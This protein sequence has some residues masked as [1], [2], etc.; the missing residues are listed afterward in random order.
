MRSVANNLV[1]SLE[2]K[3]IR[4]ATTLCH[5]GRTRNGYVAARFILLSSTAKSSATSGYV[6]VPEPFGQSEARAVR[7]AERSK[8]KPSFFPAVDLIDAIWKHM[9]TWTLSITFMY[10]V[11]C[12]SF[13]FWCIFSN[14]LLWKTCSIF[15]LSFSLLS[16][17]GNNHF[18][19]HFW[20]IRPVLFL[21]K[22]GKGTVYE[23]RNGRIGV[24]ISRQSRHFS[25]CK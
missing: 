17:R 4:C 12:I 3:P 14:F 21:S 13:I 1:T 19:L 15:C 7:N 8:K 22:E 25:L 9:Y 23:R 5:F 16:R 11:L 24:F 20:R 2:I 6:V 10:F 18:D